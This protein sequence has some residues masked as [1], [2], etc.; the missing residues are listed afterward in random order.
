MKITCNN[1]INRHIRIELEYSDTI[2]LTSPAGS[3][4][5]CVYIEVTPDGLLTLTGGASARLPGIKKT[6]RSGSGRELIWKNSV[7]TPESD[8]EWRAHI[9]D[10]M[11]KKNSTF[12]RSSDF[13]IVPFMVSINKVQNIETFKEGTDMGHTK[14]ETRAVI[15]DLVHI[16]WKV[17]IEGHKFPKKPHDFYGVIAEESAI[18][19]ALRDYRELTENQKVLQ[20]EAGGSGREL[21]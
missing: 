13:F 17:Y 4:R 8:D 6:E 16:G 18:A 14:I 5:T 9:Y 2:Q 11:A 3:S 15:K 10:E 12:A 7:C 1:E 20:G 21:K 19:R